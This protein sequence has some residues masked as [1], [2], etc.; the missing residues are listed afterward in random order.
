MTPYQ[1]RAVSY[2]E[3]DEEF[4]REGLGDWSV[5]FDSC[6]SSNGFRRG[7]VGDVEAWCSANAAS[8]YKVYW[9][10]E[11]RFFDENDAMLCLM[12]FR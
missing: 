11:V 3:N 6:L 7:I 2:V 12:A 8:D 9:S 5:M 4:R 1:A 10:G